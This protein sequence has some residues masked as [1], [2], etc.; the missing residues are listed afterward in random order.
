MSIPA[1]VATVQVAAVPSSAFSVTSVNMSIVP[2][3]NLVWATN[4]Q[5]LASMCNSYPMPGWVLLPAVDQ[6][7]FVTSDTHVGVT[8][9]KYL[10]TVNWSE[11]DGSSHTASGSIQVLVGGGIDYLVSTGGVLGSPSAGFPGTVVSMQVLT[12]AA[13]TAL[14]TPDPSTLY[15]TY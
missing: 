3:Q 9:W 8:G 15:F 11:S 14:G 2:S 4:G 12:A 1:G 7:G 10:I 6:I 13:Y 5:A